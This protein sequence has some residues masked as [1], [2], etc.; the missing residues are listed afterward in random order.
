V[1]IFFILWVSYVVLVVV[2]LADGGAG[3]WAA[4]VP[5]WHADENQNNVFQIPIM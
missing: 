1:F 3:I 4:I 2:N 5:A